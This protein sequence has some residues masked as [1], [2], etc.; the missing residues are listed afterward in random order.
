MRSQRHLVE[1]GR[2]A[3]NGDNLEDYLPFD[4][5]KQPT[6]ASISPTT[7]SKAAGVFTLTCTGTN[8][9]AECV[10]NFAGVYYPTTLVSTS[11]LTISVDPSAMTLG[12]KNCFVSKNRYADTTTR[13][14]TLNA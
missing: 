6:L 7:R 2:Q 5:T 12:T 1:L 9:D 10:V 11:S 13:T 3:S 8:Y 4:A 14:L